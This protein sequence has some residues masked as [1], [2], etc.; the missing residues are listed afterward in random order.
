MLVIRDDDTVAD[1]YL[2]EF[3]RLFSHYA[4]RESL[5]FRRRPGQVVLDPRYLVADATWFEAGYFTEGRDRCLR[6]RY[7]SDG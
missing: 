7:F 1:V 3:M 2:G 4:F 5:R 6:R